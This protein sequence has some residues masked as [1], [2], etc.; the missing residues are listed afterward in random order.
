MGRF[1]TFNTGFEYKFAFGIQ[2]SEDIT[3]FGG[4][5]ND[6]DDDEYNSY[7]SGHIWREEDKENVLN[8]LNQFG[9]G[10]VLPHF[11]RYEKSLEGTNEMLSSEPFSYDKDNVYIHRFVLG[12]LIYHQ[13]LY[14]PNLSVEYE[15]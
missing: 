15:L 10:F 14:E 3:T 13:L 12:C 1:A 6:T 5:V 7:Y 4:E 11:E 9:E 2:P 8:C